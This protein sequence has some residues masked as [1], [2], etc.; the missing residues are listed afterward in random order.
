[1]RENKSRQ[2]ETKTRE[3]TQRTLTHF[4][5]LLRHTL[6]TFNMTI[7]TSSTTLLAFLSSVPAFEMTSKGFCFAPPLLLDIQIICPQMGTD[8]EQGVLTGS[9]VL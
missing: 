4:T 5:I 9:Y 8:G 1:M 6:T 2:R 3:A 7:N